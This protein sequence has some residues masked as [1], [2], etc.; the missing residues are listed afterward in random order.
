VIGGKR[1]TPKEATATVIDALNSLQIPYMLVGSLSSS[2]YGIPRATTD[3]DFVVQLPSGGLSALIERLGPSFQLDRQ[4]T[5]ET[6]T[7][8]RRYVLYLADNPFS[9]ELFLLSDDAH[10]LERFARRRQERI[11]DREG[12]VPTMEDV[13]ITKLRWSHAGR[14]LK[15]LDDARNVITVQGDRIDW[16]YVTAWCDRH[17]TRELLESVRRM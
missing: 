6:V 12:F 3:A 4:M 15:D 17:G 14:R 16:D 5:F 13:I 9:V 2:F 7:A 10:D 8:T 11:L 1:V